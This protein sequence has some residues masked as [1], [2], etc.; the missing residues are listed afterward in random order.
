MALR[1]M[2]QAWD[3]LAEG[4]RQALFGPERGEQTQPQDRRHG[5]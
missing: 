1:E 5:D 2:A 4:R 3:A